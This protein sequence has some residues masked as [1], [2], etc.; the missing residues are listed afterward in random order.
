MKTYSPELFKAL[1]ESMTEKMRERAAI[2][3]TEFL[4]EYTNALEE[5]LEKIIVDEL[6]AF[7]KK[8]ENSDDSAA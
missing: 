6:R 5:S 8:S 2:V 7:W 4:T 1:K 3:I